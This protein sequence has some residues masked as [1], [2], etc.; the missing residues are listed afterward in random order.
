VEAEMA[1]KKV[2][3]LK[4]LEEEKQLQEVKKIHE[5]QVRKSYLI[6]L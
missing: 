1:K 6:D 2:K 4:Q 5:E 3:E